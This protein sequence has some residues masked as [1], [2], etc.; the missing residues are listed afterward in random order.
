MKDKKKGFN[1][2][3]VITIAIIVI[4]VLFVGFVTAIGIH[5]YRNR[6]KV[7][8]DGLVITDTKITRDGDYYS[9]QAK[10]TAEEAKRVKKITVIFKDDKDNVVIKINNI[11]N[12]DFKVGDYT[13]II[14]KTDININDAKKIEYKV[15]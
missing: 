8:I 3:N 1:I 10:V 12:K 7:F 14:S 2:N 5:K 11:L 9:F 6:N 15:E 4:A 13:T